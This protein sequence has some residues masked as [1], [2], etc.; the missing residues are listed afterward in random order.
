[1]RENKQ[2]KG[3]N[4]PQFAIS[5]ILAIAVASLLIMVSGAIVLNATDMPDVIGVQNMTTQPI[6]NIVNATYSGLNLMTVLPI[7]LVASL[8]ISLIA[9][10]FMCLRASGACE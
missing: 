4:I 5:I 2:H 10:S 1:M 7:V 8:V 9:G 6:Y 3:V